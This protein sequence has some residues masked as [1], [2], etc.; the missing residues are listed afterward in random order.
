MFEIVSYCDK[1]VKVFPIL[2]ILWL[3]QVYYLMCTVNAAMQAEKT[4]EIILD[5]L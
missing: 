1:E 4:L 5:L 3:S 2:E